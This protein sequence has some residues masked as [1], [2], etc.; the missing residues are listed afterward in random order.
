MYFLAPSPAMGDKHWLKN[1]IDTKRKCFSYYIK[2][3]NCKGSLQQVFIR[4]YRLESGD[5]VSHVGIF[6]PASWTDTSYLLSVSTLL[7]LSLFH[8]SKYSI[9]RQCVAGSGWGVFSPIGDHILWEYNTLYLNSLRTYKIARPPKQKPS[10][11]GSLRQI[12]T[13]RKSPFTGQFF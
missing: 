10:R 2:K 12:N 6:D 7:P 1:Y 8:V 3:L 9:Y 11:G 5:T 4:V 13:R